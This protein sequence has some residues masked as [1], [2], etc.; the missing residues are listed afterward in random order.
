MRFFA[1]ARRAGFLITF[2]AHFQHKKYVRP[3]GVTIKAH[4]SPSDNKNT[5]LNCRVAK[6]IFDKFLKNRIFAD[7]LFKGPI[8]IQL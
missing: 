6:K 3:S 7:E 8:E 4:P 5:R 1:I 2:V